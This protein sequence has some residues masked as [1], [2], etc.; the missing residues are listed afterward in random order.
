MC[1]YN[2][3]A[4]CLLII[5]LE[6]EM[7]QGSLC[8]I[9]TLFVLV[10]QCSNHQKVL[11]A[12]GQQS[13]VKKCNLP[14]KITDALEDGSNYQQQPRVFYEFGQQRTELKE[15][16]LPSSSGLHYVVKM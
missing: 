14:P 2:S 12:D 3:L 10:H 1:K 4:D 11:W 16:S 8:H 7:M 15:C 5:Y 6:L 13:W 9:V